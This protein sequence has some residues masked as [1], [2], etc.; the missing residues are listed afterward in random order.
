MY[1]D[2]IKVIKELPSTSPLRR[3]LTDAFATFYSA[4]HHLRFGVDRAL[5]QKLPPH[6]LSQGFS[7][8]AANR[9]E[10]SFLKKLR[11]PCVYHKHE[12][13]DM[14]RQACKAKHEALYKRKR[15]EVKRE[16]LISKTFA[17]AS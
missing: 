10:P 1:Q 13:T 16:Q 3:L 15:E 14:A 17:S 7:L 12:N 5:I 2:M 9:D 4:E 11:A 6:L 8:L